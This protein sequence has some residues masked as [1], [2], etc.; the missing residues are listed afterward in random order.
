[1]CVWLLGLLAGACSPPAANSTEPAPTPPP[2]SAPPAAATA[3]ATSAIGNV[4]TPSVT[5]PPTA[6]YL[7]TAVPRT[8]TPL[9]GSVEVLVVDYIFSPDVITI[10]AGTTV[11]WVPSGSAEHSIVPVDPPHP[12]HGGSTAGSGSPT[13]TWTFGQPGTYPYYCDYHPGGMVGIVTVVGRE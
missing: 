12:W 7:P 6:T 9:S 4:L 11:N 8:A 13:V 3:R 5:R 2:A 1:M 10:T